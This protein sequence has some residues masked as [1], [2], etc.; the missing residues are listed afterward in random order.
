MD[1]LFVILASTLAVLS[2]VG[3]VVPI[4]PG[5]LFAYCAMLALLPTKFAPAM[6]TCVAFG[7]GCAAVLVL[8]WIVPAMGARRFNCSKAGVLGCAAGTVVG[9]FF[10]PVGLVAG[11]FAGAVIGE[12]IAGKR[13]SDSVKGGFGAL[14]GFLCGVAVKIS[15]CT[16]C[17]IWCACM[18]LR[19]QGA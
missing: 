13:L 15:Y 18:V 1:M 9:L 8:D 4:L 6:H 19:H 14:L 16:A 12:L 7:A 11:P 5:P 2:F 17:V 3:C 10:A